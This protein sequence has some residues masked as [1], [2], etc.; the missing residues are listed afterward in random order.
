MLGIAGHGPLVEAAK[1]CTSELVTNVFRHTG[2]KLVHVEVTLG[3]REVSVYVY[4]DQPRALAVPTE[5]MPAIREDGRGLILV[6]D[7]ADAWGATYFGGLRPHS[8]AVWFRMVKG[9]RGAS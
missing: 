6:N 3:D 8:K 2:A 5:I 1:I 4:D 7:L 9:G